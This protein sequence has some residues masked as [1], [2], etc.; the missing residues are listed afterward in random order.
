MD[1]TNF[2]FRTAMRKNSQGPRASFFTSPPSW[3][4]ET[5]KPVN[6]SPRKTGSLGMREERRGRK[7]KDRWGEG[8]RGE[9]RGQKPLK[10]WVF[11][12]GREGLS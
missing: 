9:G 5:I 3:E 1:D 10:K 4:W 7:E 8:R 12:V 11:R 2:T 6:E